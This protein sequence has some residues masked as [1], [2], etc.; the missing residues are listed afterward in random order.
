MVNSQK[1]IKLGDF[2][3]S[4]SLQQLE[5]F[6]VLDLNLNLGKFSLE[7]QIFVTVSTE[8]WDGVVLRSGNTSR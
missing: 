2:G 7:F 4:V 5:L 6:K 8:G 1:W 3:N